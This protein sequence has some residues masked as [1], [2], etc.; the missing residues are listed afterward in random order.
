MKTILLI[1][2]NQSFR[3]IMTTVLLA[4]DYDVLE[5]ACPDDAFQLLEKEQVDLIL[6]DLHMPFTMGPRYAEFEH[7]Y[8]VGVKTIQELSVVYPRLPIIAMTSTD[9]SD[10]SKITRTL[11]NIPTFTKPNTTNELLAIVEQCFD[12]QCG[13]PPQ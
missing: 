13:I 5:A 10:L 11:E 6:C 8:N 3:E 1:D 12:I 9:P 4:A 7:S 2:D